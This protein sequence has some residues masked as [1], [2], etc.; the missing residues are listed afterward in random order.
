MLLLRIVP[1]RKIC[2][3]LEL[4]SVSYPQ[5]LTIFHST[6]LSFKWQSWKVIHQLFWIQWSSEECMCLA[7]IQTLCYLCFGE[8]LSKQ[9]VFL[10][11]VFVRLVHFYFFFCSPHWTDAFS[12][13]MWLFPTSQS[14]P[15]GRASPALLGINVMSDWILRLLTITALA[16]VGVKKP[17]NESK[18]TPAPLPFL[19]MLD[20][21]SPKMR[22]MQCQ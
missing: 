17:G 18:P 21:G 15:D 16:A 12:F 5:M 2:L 14:E 11:Y 6:S 3:Q 10:L 4:V 22:D 8:S 20:M 13:S 1:S 7:A 19:Y 9:G